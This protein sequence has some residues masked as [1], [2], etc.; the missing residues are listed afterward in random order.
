M[1]KQNSISDPLFETSACDSDYKYTINLNAWGDMI[2][3]PYV[4]SRRTLTNFEKGLNKERF[5]E[6]RLRLLDG[7]DPLKV[8]HIIIHVSKINGVAEEAMR[9]NQDDPCMLRVRCYSIWFDDSGNF[10]RGDE[11]N[12]SDW[13]LKKGSPP[14]QGEW[15][16]MK[17]RDSYMQTFSRSFVEYLPL[18]LFLLDDPLVHQWWHRETKGAFI[19]QSVLGGVR[20]HD[21][22]GALSSVLGERLYTGSS[23]LEFYTATQGRPDDN[24]YYSSPS[25]R[26]AMAV[27]QCAYAVPKIQ[28]FGNF[29]RGLFYEFYDK[30]GNSMHTRRLVPINPETRAT[31]AGINYG[32]SKANG[33]GQHS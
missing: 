30:R 31:A 12:V 17:S 26:Q 13:V 28:K 22:S 8:I 2:I 1:S 21:Q 10:H 5:S 9:M 14:N 16:F 20:R 6:F 18:E 15:D 32:L 29:T 11:M 3:D 33:F 4:I 27:A 24:I 19:P 25:Q 7:R 23:A